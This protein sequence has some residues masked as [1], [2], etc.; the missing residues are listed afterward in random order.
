M[1]TPKPFPEGK[2]GVLDTETAQIAIKNLQEMPDLSF[3]RGH[4]QALNEILS[5]KSL[6]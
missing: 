3:L 4:E 6:E 1:W 5:L 2:E